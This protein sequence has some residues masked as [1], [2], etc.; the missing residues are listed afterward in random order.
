M[1]NTRQTLIT[2]IVVQLPPSVK[3]R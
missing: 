2:I 3:T 1:A